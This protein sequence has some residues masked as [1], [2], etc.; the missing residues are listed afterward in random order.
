MYFGGT[1]SVS[2]T[3]GTREPI[4]LL[5]HLLSASRLEPTPDDDVVGVTSSSALDVCRESLFSA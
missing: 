2:P 5:D 1:S 3:Y 4:L